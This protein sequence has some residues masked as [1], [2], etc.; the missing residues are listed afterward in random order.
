M[1]EIDVREAG[2]RL[3]AAVI[4]AYGKPGL[5]RNQS[6]LSAAS[7]VSRSVLDGWWTGTMPKPENMQRVAGALGVPAERLWLRWLGYELPEPGLERIADEIKALRTAITLAGGGDAQFRD[8]L[9][10]ID[11]ARAD[12]E[13]EP[14]ADPPAEPVAS[15]QRHT[16]DA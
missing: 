12:P 1:P 8:A 13:V 9:A 5:V 14:E 7:G 3:S 11:E 6:Q 16:P 4:E 15:V 2:E 10:A